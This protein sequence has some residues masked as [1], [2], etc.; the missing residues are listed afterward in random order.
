MWLSVGGACGGG[1]GAVDAAGGSADTG[2][3]SFIE[4]TGDLTPSGEVSLARNIIFMMGDGMGPAQVRAGQ[5]SAGREMRFE[6]LPGPVHFNTDS[7]TTDES[8]DPAQAPTD[9]AAAATA[10]AT[11]TRTENDRVGVDTLSQ[12]VQNFSELARSEGK[13]IGLVTTSF[14]YDA[15][16]MSFLVHVESRDNHGLILTELFT[17]ALPDLL[18]GGRLDL[19]EDSHSV[20][21]DMATDAGYTI[22]RDKDELAA[23]NPATD[24]MALGV[25]DAPE[26]S[27]PSL[28]DWGTT[29][30]IMRD[31][32]TTDPDLVEMTTRALDR[33][34]TD[35]DGFFLFVE[36]E[37]I[38]TLGHIAV[39]ERDL[40]PAAM[41][42]EVVAF[43]DAVGVVL[44][45]IDANSSYDET[46]LIVAADHETG[47]Y[48]LYG[49][50][51]NDALF[52]SPEHSRTPPGL[53]AR[54]PGAENAAAICRISDVHLLLT[55]QLP[56]P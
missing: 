15:S 10:M 56:A 52:W 55:G 51:L 19:L 46:L 42:L 32:N 34:A 9:S 39:V 7:I 12:P 48:Q 41:P 43:D 33:M 5:I 2:F 47:T 26:S 4:C 8:P 20:Y 1:D 50:D 25:F 3:P 37:H 16:P 53:W 49:P 18:L 14:A 17:N 28:F 13:A 36:N 38:D 23:W 31:D 24:P 35:P 27:V 54:G 11:G 45:W 21:L 40:A 44:D 22:L 29:P 6:S 30:T